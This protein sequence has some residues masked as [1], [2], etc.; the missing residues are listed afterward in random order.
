MKFNNGN[1]GMIV[2]GDLVLDRDT[3]YYATMNTSGNMINMPGYSH[4]KVAIYD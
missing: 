2:I 4:P 3:A 1:N